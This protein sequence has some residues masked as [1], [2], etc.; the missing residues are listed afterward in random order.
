MIRHAFD[1]VSLQTQKHNGTTLVIVAIAS[2]LIV[3]YIITSIR[4][5]LA[6]KNSRYGRR[7]PILPYWL[8]FIGSAISFYTSGPR[9]ATNLVYV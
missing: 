9:V 7:P 3:T 5:A 8:P 1:A 2:L 4:S 6:M